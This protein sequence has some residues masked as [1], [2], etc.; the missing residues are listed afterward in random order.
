MVLHFRHRRMTFSYFLSRGGDNKCRR[1]YN[2]LLM[3]P[4]WYWH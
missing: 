4:D 1:R 3:I 2:S